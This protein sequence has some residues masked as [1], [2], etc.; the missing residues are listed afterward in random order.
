MTYRYVDPSRET[1]LYSLPDVEIWYTKKVYKESG[2]Y[3]AYGFPGCFHDSDP[4]GPF[5]TEQDALDD[6]REPHSRIRWN[7]W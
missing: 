2:F 4:I 7:R 3:Y 5:K 1:D 6:A